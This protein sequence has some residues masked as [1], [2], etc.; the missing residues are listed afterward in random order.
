MV[1]ESV[2][3][4]HRISRRRIEVDHS[5]I[6]GIEKLLMIASANVY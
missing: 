3:I 2:V 5:K 6:E 1:I 4:G